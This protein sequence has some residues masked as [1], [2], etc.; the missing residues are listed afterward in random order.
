MQNHTFCSKTKMKLKLLLKYKNYKPK[1]HV[2]LKFHV[3]KQFAT[4]IKN[5]FKHPDS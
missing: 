5:I 1:S 4:A 3:S 2:V